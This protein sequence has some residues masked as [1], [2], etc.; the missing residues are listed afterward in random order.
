[1]SCLMSWD[2]PAS[3]PSW[4][5]ARGCIRFCSSPR[6]S[7]KCLFRPTLVSLNLGW[8]CLGWQVLHEPFKRLWTLHWRHSFGSLS[9]CSLT[10]SWYTA[11][12]MSSTCFICCKFSSCSLPTSGSSRCLSVRRTTEYQLPGLCN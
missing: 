2:R 11:P 3:F 1:M 4:I 9:W 12:L 7:T 6:R 8:C 10:I 5:C